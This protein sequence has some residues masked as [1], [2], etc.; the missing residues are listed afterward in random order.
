M[1]PITVKDQ[2][3]VGD[4]TVQPNSNKSVKAAGTR[5]RRRL[6]KSFHCDST[7]RGFFCGRVPGLLAGT[8][9]SS[10]PASC[11]SPR[12]QRYRRTTSVLYRAG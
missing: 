5:L 4:N 11:Q 8:R 9:G 7:E 6:S 2:N 10:H 12:I 3:Q 1:I